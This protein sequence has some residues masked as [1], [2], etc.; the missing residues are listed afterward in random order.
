LLQV[1]KAFYVIRLV[2]GA[3]RFG[4]AASF[5]SGLFVEQS[6]ALR[7]LAFEVRMREPA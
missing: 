2:G 5:L 1:K 4:H 3:Y 7:E 6:P